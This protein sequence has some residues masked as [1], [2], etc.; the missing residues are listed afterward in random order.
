[1]IGRPDLLPSGYTPGDLRELTQAL[2]LI[3]VERAAAQ[4]PRPVLISA[5]AIS[6]MRPNLRCVVLMS[7]AA[8]RAIDDVDPKIIRD[9][10]SHSTS[11]SLSPLSVRAWKTFSVKLPFVNPRNDELAIAIRARRRL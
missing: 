4:A 11:T 5:A 3:G 1:M 2:G 6:Q 8:Q 7:A 9:C 10:A